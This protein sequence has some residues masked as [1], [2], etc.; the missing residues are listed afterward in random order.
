VASRRLPV[1]WILGATALALAAAA[2]VV[3]FAGVGSGDDD[4]SDGGVPAADTAALT[5]EGELPESVH[6]I[7]LGAL[8]GGADRVL[9]ELMDGRPLVVNFFASWCQPC[10]EEMPAFERVHQALG[11]EVTIVGLALPPDVESAPELVADTGVTYPT[12]ADADGAA[13]TFFEGANMPTT[14]FL[15][16]DGAVREVNTGELRE[17]EILAKLDEHFGIR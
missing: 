3:V 1:S 10:I 16:P 2:A 15:A 5:P 6:A 9:H 8:D 14:V 7:Q 13:F 17:Q 4:S 12:Y 11:D